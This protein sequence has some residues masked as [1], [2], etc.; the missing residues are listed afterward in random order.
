MPEVRITIGGR[1]FEVAC[2]DGEESYLHAAAKMLDDEAQVLSDQV[3]RMPESR[4]LLMAGLLLA[5]K[6]ASVE[7]RI[8]EIRAELAQREAELARLRN[9]RVEPE[10]I[11]VPVV[12]Q[13]V[14][15]TL[16]EIAARAEALA[17]EVEEKAAG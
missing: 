1:Q 12:P 7:D 10:R 13:S 2:Q 16:A 14:T 11:E 5:D 17:A 15:D 6:T 9:V 4:M 3:G 8:A